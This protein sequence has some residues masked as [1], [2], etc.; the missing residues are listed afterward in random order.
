[1]QLRVPLLILA[2]AAISQ[3]TFAQQRNLNYSNLTQGQRLDGF[4]TVAVYQDDSDRAIG[5]RF[6]HE[7][8]GFTLDLLQIQTAP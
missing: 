5:A 6:L 7:R 2:A 4:R 1:M 8:T 3:A